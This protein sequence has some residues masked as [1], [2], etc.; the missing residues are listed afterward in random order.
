[1]GVK[2]RLARGGAKK[3][4]HYNI[5]VSPSRT[6]RDGRFIEKIGTYDPNLPSEHAG[7]LKLDL[8]RT[9]YWLG[10][11]A[12]P[13]DRVKR[14]LAAAGVL[15][16]APRAFPQ[17][18]KPKAKAQARLKAAEEAKAGAEASPGG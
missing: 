3:Q 4:A 2:I 9:K 11:G 6:P 5:V 12:E 1:M 10:H 17:K 15:E 7:R 14:F 8:E 18:G 13:T 16:R